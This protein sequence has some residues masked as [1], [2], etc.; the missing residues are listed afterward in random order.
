M[1]KLIWAVVGVVSVL[2]CSSTDK[3]S[4]GPVDPAA[5]DFCLHWANEVCG[6]A[7]QCTAATA[8]DAAFHSRYGK[9]EDDCWEGLDKLC[10]SN[11]TGSQTFGPSCGPGKKVNTTLSDG[12]FAGLDAQTCSVWSSA[13]DGPC[14]FVCDAPTNPGT[15]AGGAGNGAGGGGAGT[16]GTPSAGATSTGSLSTVYDFCVQFQNVGCEREFECDPTGAM[17][18]FASVAECKSS[19]PTFCSSVAACPGGYDANS[20]P[21]CLAAAKTATCAELNGDPPAVCTATCAQ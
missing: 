18:A 1:S 21:G 12:C 3:G 10:E 20:A 4:A 9:S 7:Y 11:Q 5:Q 8:Q 15:G 14:D 17:M 16:P 13:Q 6:L 2:G 19:V